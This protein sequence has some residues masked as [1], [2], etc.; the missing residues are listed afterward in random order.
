MP[1][2]ALAV[3]MIVAGIMALL[4]V[5]ILP[6]WN[7]HPGAIPKEV[8]ITEEGPAFVVRASVCGGTM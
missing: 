5:W 2:P 8:R 1:V 4:M 7:N 6:L 3:Q